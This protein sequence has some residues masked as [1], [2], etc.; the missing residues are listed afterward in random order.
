MQRSFLIYPVLIFFLGGLAYVNS[1]G[2]GFTFDDGAIVL[3]NPVIRVWNLGA[4][5]S[6]PWWPGRADIGLYRPLTTLTFALNYQAH[7]VGPY[8]YHLVNVLLHL[9]NGALVF[10]IAFRVLG[11]AAAAGVTALVF[12]LHPIQTEAVN[13][14]VGRAELLSAFWVLFAWLMYLVASYETGRLQ[15][16]LYNGALV[17]GFVGCFAKEHAAV[18][19]GFLAV[20][21]FVL[22]LRRGEA[23]P[24]RYF[25]RNDVKRYVPFVLIVGVFLAIRHL[26]VGAILLPSQPLLVDNSLAY[27]PGWQRA[28]TAIAILGKYVGLLVAPVT[29][30]A[31]YSFNQIPAVA[32]VFDFRFLAGLGVVAAT[33]FV[34]VQG[35]RGRLDPVWGFGP[36]L[37]LLALLPVSNLL[38]P[39]GTILGERLLY[40][41]SIGFCFLLGVGY[42]RLTR[43]VM[44]VWIPVTIAGLLLGV[45]SVRTHL[46]NLDWRNDFT[47]FSATVR[48]APNSAK[49]HFNLGSA[50]REQGELKKA[51]DAYWAALEI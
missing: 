39:I 45:Y 14:L 11:H 36:A 9:L 27:L 43:T 51:L 29:L 50:F 10:W 47:L 5:F 2:N 23:S 49:A 8:G 26:V 31:D 13:G 19:V 38:F 28:L 34:I 17:A 41:P 48:S 24:F 40:L 20:Y 35:V 1:L 30:S 46:R 44:P 25:L 4:I 33:V 15:R 22:V 42:R 3:N 18:L 37:I 12:V 32:S 16:V 6:E 7:D 21:D